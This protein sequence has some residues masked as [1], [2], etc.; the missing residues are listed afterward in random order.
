MS[1]LSSSTT[2]I[3]TTTTTIFSNK[4]CTCFYISS[5]WWK[6]LSENNKINKMEK[7]WGQGY[8]KLREW[9][10]IVAGPKWINFIRRFD[11]KRTISLNY[12]PLSYALN[13]DDGSNDHGEEEKEIK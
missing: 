7:W 13:F 8:K 2:A 1:S 9:S 3:T 10:Q 5:Q 4:A 11:K 12:D 6:R